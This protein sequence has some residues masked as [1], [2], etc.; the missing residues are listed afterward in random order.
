M[1]LTLYKLLERINF[2]L[3]FPEGVK[4]D[5]ICKKFVEEVRARVRDSNLKID[6]KVNAQ[7]LGI[8][9][10][11][12][13][14]AWVRA[15]AEIGHPLQ[16]DID[17]LYAIKRGEGYELVGVEVKVLELSRGREVPY[18][19][20]SRDKRGFYAGLDE[21]LALLTWGVDYAYLWH[22]VWDPEKLMRKALEKE[23]PAAQ[24]FMYYGIYEG[25][26]SC[27][28]EEC[29]LPLGYLFTVASKE[30]DK[31]KFFKEDEFV[32]HEEPKSICNPFLEKEPVKKLRK[33][34]IQYVKR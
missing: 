2:R 33:H 17:M 7:K 27:L 12:G 31:L 19:P 22:I 16:P 10:G 23:R 25:I 5:D 34:L 29:K 1:E 24:R 13:E 14:E 28:V 26:V 9:K 18:I 20:R 4:E 11:R 3:P 8:V 21:A 30:G 15:V 6:S 32:L